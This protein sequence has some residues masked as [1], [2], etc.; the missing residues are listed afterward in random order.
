MC[1]NYKEAKQVATGLNIVDKIMM[2]EK[3]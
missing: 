3:W 1:R 2:E